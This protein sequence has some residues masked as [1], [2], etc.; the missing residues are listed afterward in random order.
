MQFS[1]YNTNNKKTNIHHLVAV[2][3]LLLHTYTNWMVPWENPV[4]LTWAQDGG[5]QKPVGEHAL[6][7]EKLPRSGTGPALREKEGTERKLQA[8]MN[9]ANDMSL[10]KFSNGW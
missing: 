5:E 6:D 8:I 3:R 9:K 10:E 2:T 7:S 4:G 1:Y